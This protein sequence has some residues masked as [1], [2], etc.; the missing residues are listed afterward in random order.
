MYFKRLLF[1][2]VALLILF[3]NFGNNA[4]ANSYKGIVLV[5]NYERLFIDT[6]VAKKTTVSLQQEFAS[7]QEELKV[8]AN[9]LVTDA[10]NLDIQA[11]QLSQTDLIS[12]QN[13]VRNRD[14]QL[15]SIN[16]KFIEDVSK[17]NSEERDKIDKIIKG[18]LNKYSEKFNVSLILPEAAYINN[19]VDITEDIIALI[20]GTKNLESI[21]YN[22]PKEIS[23]ALVNTE[24]IMQD[25]ALAKS[26]QKSI[27]DRY[28]PA[29]SEEKNKQY[30]AARIDI[31]NKA[32][33]IA[34]KFAQKNNID[35]ILENAA[36]LNA[37]ID[38]T[39]KIIEIMDGSDSYR[40]DF[41]PRVTPIAF[42]NA[43]QIFNT[44]TNLSRQTV[45]EAANP[46]IKDF[47]QK[48]LLDLVVQKAVFVSPSFDITSQV[49][50]VINL[51]REAR[52]IENTANVKKPTSS[53]IDE[54]KRKCSE[55][56][57]KSGTEGFGKC[58]L[59]LLE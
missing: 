12:R 27:S 37:D 21:T 53:K 32:N 6:N 4:Y 52:N 44:F 30:Q 24:L 45:I 33:P 50:P 31:V 14:L 22:G 15:Q 51:S 35:I 36:Y 56:G 47:S 26:H 3:S 39:R 54:S 20:N 10:K 41:F 8:L 58:V 9:A 2:F 18:W 48:K 42:V 34:R 11:S 40:S 38:I 59:R 13:E 29:S 19:K 28:G 57:F 17:R 43:E 49:L 55:L 23:V 5:V 1:I 7:R 25:S 46:A 16:N